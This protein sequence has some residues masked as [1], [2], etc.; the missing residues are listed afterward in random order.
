MRKTLLF[1][2]V[3]LELAGAAA[4]QPLMLTATDFRQQALISDSFE[5][6]SSRL[7]LQKSRN[8]RIRSF[9]S[10]MIRDHSMT[11]AALTGGVFRSALR[12]EC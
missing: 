10:M 4:A 1:T 8:P 2:V 11:T 9:A 7:A 3:L 12:S 5:I 6:E